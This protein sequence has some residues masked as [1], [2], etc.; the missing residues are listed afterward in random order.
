MMFGYSDEWWVLLL[1]PVVLWVPFGPFAMVWLGVWCARAPG[2]RPRLWSVLVP[3]IPVVTSAVFMTFPLSRWEWTLRVDGAK[4][5]PE[6]LDDFLGYLLVYIGGITV[7]PWLL[8]YGVTRLLRFARARRARPGESAE[9]SAAR[10]PATP[11]EGP[12][13]GAGAG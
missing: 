11:A 3:L 1:Y 7:L 8:G 6:H 13:G 10:T 5:P 9:G 4:E 2:P 12:S